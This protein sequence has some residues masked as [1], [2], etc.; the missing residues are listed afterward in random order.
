[1]PR[2]RKTPPEELIRA[3]AD[4]AFLEAVRGRALVQAVRHACDG[5]RRWF[6]D[7]PRQWHATSATVAHAYGHDRGKAARELT[8]GVRQGLLRN[9]GAR[10]YVL[11]EY[12]ETLLEAG[13]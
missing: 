8:W 9:E 11:T 5:R 3:A 10:R 12:G 7:L 6:P 13:A 4:E 1:M 2:G